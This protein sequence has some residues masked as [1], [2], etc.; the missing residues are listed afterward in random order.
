MKKI[1]YLLFI[2][3]ALFSCASGNNEEEQNQN[4]VEIKESDIQ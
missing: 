3:F 1:F 2:S 4:N